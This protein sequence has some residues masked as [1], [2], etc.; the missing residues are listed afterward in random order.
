MGYGN[1][2][3]IPLTIGKKTYCVE[4]IYKSVKSEPVCTDVW[5]TI[6]ISENKTNINVYPNPATDRIT[7]ETSLNFEKI[8]IYNLNGQEV[9]YHQT[10]REIIL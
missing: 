2:P 8:S 7:I 5:I 1:C 3:Y 10:P 6:G 4:A 9:Y